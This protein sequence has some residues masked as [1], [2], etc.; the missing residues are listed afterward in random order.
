MHP[1]GSLKSFIELG[2]Q[3]CSQLNRWSALH[4]KSVVIV[5]T[6]TLA[7]KYIN[8]LCA[9]YKKGL[10]N[11]RFCL[12]RYMS[13][14]D[15]VTH[16]RSMVM[17]GADFIDIGAQSTRPGATRLSDDEELSRLVPVLEAISA[18]PSLQGVPLSVDTFSAR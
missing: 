9:K 7:S 11:I 2:R 15:A 6:V 17:E 16:I 18:D 1:A 3:Q 10:S 4:L 14:K 12:H 8:Y 5:V 13:V